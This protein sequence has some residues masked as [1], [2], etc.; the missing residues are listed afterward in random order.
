MSCEFCKPSMVIRDSTFFE[1]LP[2]SK[3]M[4]G[5]GGALAI[6]AKG[7]KFFLRYENDTSVF[8]HDISIDEYWPIAY[9]PMCGAKLPSKKVVE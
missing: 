2:E 5:Y 8:H 9:C 1:H 6:H 4:F 3:S 7:D